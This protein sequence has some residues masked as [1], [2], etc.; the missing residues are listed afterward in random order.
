MSANANMA[1]RCVVVGQGTLPQACAEILLGQGYAVDAVITGDARFSAWAAAHGVASAREPEALQAL[2]ERGIDLLFSIVNPH[3]LP[4]ALLAGVR[5]H[6]INYHDAPLPRYAG[7]CATAWA[8]IAGEKRHGVSWHLMSGRVDS[9]DILAQ[10]E[11]AIT[12]DDTSLSLNIKCYDAALRSFA[13]LTEQLLEGEPVRRRQDPAQRSFFARSKRPH[14][15]CALDLRRLVAELSALVRALQFGPYPNGLGLPKLWLGDGF[16]LVG[17]LAL[18]DTRS[19]CAAGTVLAIDERGIFVAAA[20]GDVQLSKLS[21]P[22]GTPLGAAD[23]A[24]RH[25]LAAGV[26]VPPLTQRM[27][28]SFDE[29][30]RG[31]AMHEA[32][33][34]E[35]LRQAR[36]FQFARNVSRPI[37]AQGFDTLAPQGWTGI[38]LAVAFAAY[39]AR[40]EGVPAIDLGL[41]HPGSLSTHAGLLART[42]P[43]RLAFPGAVCVA[44]AMEQGRDAFAQACAH[45][46]HAC[47]LVLRHPDLGRERAGQTWPVV[48]RLAPCS[49]TSVQAEP[50]TLLLQIASD[51][52]QLRFE[53]DASAFGDEQARNFAVRF[54]AFA[55]RLRTTP[56]LPLRETSLLDALEAQRI[57]RHWNDTATDYS[58]DETVDGRFR[59]RAALQPD[60]IALSWRGGAMSYRELDLRT[61]QLAQRLRLAGAEPEARVAL[62]I[63]RSFLTVIAMLAVLKSGAAYVPLDP[64][65]PVERLAYMLDDSAP[66]LLLTEPR[67]RDTLPAR[68]IETL[69]LDKIDKL[70]GDIPAADF[71]HHNQLD[72][73]NL[74][75]IIY[76]SGSTGQ[77]KGVCITHRAINQFISG[78]RHFTLHPDDVVAQAANSSFDAITFEVWGALLHGCRLHVLDYETV[79]APHRLAAEIQ[80]AQISVMLVTT[81][82]FNHVSVQAPAAFSGMRVLLFGGD[83][84]DPCAVSAV[85]EHSAPEIM[86]NCYGPTETTTYSLSHQVAGEDCVRAG[87]PIGRPI[88]NTRAYVLDKNYL[89]VPPGTVGELYIGGDG[90]ARGYANRP[91]LSAERFLPDPFSAIPGERM[92]RSGDLVRYLE[93][94]LVE[95]VGRVDRQV[96][97]RGFRIEPGEIDVAL[98]SLPDVAEGVTLVHGGG[99]ADKRLIAYVSLRPGAVQSAGELKDALRARLPSYMVPQQILLLE[100][101]P[102]TAN[103]K[104]DRAA[105]PPPEPGEGGAGYWPPKGEIERQLALIWARTLGLP[106]AGA[107]DNF[108]DMGGHSLMGTALMLS[109]RREMHVDLPLRTLFEAPT[110][111]AMALRIDAAKAASALAASMPWS[112][113]QNWSSAG[114]NL[115]R[116]APPP[117]AARSIFLIPGGGGSAE[118]FH[119]VARALVEQGAHVYVLHHDGVD[120]ESPPA[121]AIAEMARCYAEQILPYCGAGLVAFAGYC[122]GGV[123]AHEIGKLLSD[124]GVAP[125]GMLF[126]DTPLPKPNA[127]APFDAANA[128]SEFFKAICDVHAM[129]GAG[130][131][132]ASFKGLDLDACI[133]LTISAMGERAMAEARLWESIFRRRYEAEIAHLTAI[134]A[135]WAAG[136]T[137]RFAGELAHA[138]WRLAMFN[139]S[140]SH[141]TC[142]PGEAGP[143]SARVSV[144]EGR[145]VTVL[146]EHAGAVSRLLLEC[147]EPAAQMAALIGMDEQ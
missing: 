10:E 49:H 105:L 52:R 63:E 141:A 48:V 111:A 2:L 38:D 132:A 121:A 96:K 57:L 100:R 43:V 109:I 25:S 55:E 37:A 134:H 54:L 61:D 47:D 19:G 73:Q 101:M 12:P 29:V 76:T 23:L 56:A 86:L 13:A 20:D 32:Y 33:W 22:D 44:D 108:F 66:V 81:A 89:P 110:V 130:I 107:H 42:V 88:A 143:V 113:E 84:A 116:L 69:C 139:T 133:A 14:A 46:S 68:A 27:S 40:L 127:D 53:Y 39:L 122:I 99:A 117:D 144:V 114:R 41:Q 35:Q 51:G 4:D 26:C 7:T 103:G 112:L 30:W 136:G 92:Y 36:P 98:A 65:Y 64:S 67:L 79:A 102:L 62:C 18:V 128:R 28:E 80:K 95:Y 142:W 85:L 140:E 125:R 9:G 126:V 24:V 137:G 145:H 60:R 70:P 8:L 75:C 72:P 106:R 90:L 120:N 118:V 115:S 5:R 104:I 78:T 34:L 3:I 59:T 71:V 16:I 1:R 83:A 87:F 58:R 15:A 123:I 131:E 50:C 11:V 129:Q 124:R 82:L 138:P 77:P 45:G 17:S 147:F 74:A 21:A 93:S 94:G 119:G 91:E 146:Q 6:A 31:T 97:I 135:Y